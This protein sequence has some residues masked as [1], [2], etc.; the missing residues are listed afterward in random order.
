[1]AGKIAQGTTIAR[2]TSLGSGSFQT[3]ANV[4]GWDGPS[5]QNAEID[6]TSLSSAAKEFL[7]G[8]VDYGELT[9]DVNFDPNNAGHQLCMADQEANPPTV[10]NWRITFVN[11]TINWTWNAYVKSCQ[12]SGKVD[13]K[14]TAK[15][16]LRISGA[17]TVS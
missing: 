3:I 1:M 8:L 14:V 9:L 11:P 15:L 4:S 5:L 17:R 7:G 10:T 2:E 12:V 6:V 16:T 13:D